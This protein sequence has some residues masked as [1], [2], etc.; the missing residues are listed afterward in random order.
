MSKKDGI[1]GSKNVGKYRL[2]SWVCPGSGWLDENG[3]EVPPVAA[4]FQMTDGEG[5]VKNITL[6]LNEIKNSLLPF[7]EGHKESAIRRIENGIPLSTNL[8]EVQ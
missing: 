7:V 2:V 4:M 1:C 3:N 5:G 6:D 8:S